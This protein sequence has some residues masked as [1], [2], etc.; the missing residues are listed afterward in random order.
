MKRKPYRYVLFLLLNLIQIII[1]IIPYKLAVNIGT[2]LGSIAYLILPKY[3]GLTIQNLHMAFEGEKD[4]DEILKIARDVFRN[5][6][7]TAAEYMSLRKLSK[8]EIKRYS[9]DEVF[10]PI[11]EALSRG[12]GLIVIGSHFGNW[13]MSSILG[14]AF[15]FDVT[16]IARRI[17]Y[18][19]YNDF[20]V[21]IRESKGV[22]TL[23][24][25]EKNILRKSLAVLKSNKVLGVVPDQDVDSVEGVFVNFFGRPAYTPSGPAA[26]ALLSGAPLIPVFTVRENGRLRLKIEN[27]IYVEKSG[28]KSED[29]ITYT[30]KWSDVVEKYI[31][32]Y[33]SQWVWM[34]RR[35]KTR[36]SSESKREKIDSISR[37]HA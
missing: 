7:R 33:P 2:G 21:S 25:D 24:R 14:A 6:G 8:E 17:Y 34:H 15:G 13:E 20:L 18:P 9:Q 35:W 23:Y 16:V 19:P 31:R 37:T 3:R 10:E 27:P 30:Q 26:I 5:L 29:I 11:R 28:D 1:Y 32:E 36:P 22:K 4:E 12:K